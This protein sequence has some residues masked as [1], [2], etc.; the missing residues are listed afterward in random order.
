MQVKFTVKGPKRSLARMFT[1][2]VGVTK[3]LSE[4]WLVQ[5]ASGLAEEVK[6]GLLR[7]RF[8]LSEEW[9]PLDP[10]YLKTKKKKKLD[11]RTL[12]ATK[13]Y[14]A[15]IASWR[16]GGVIMVGVRDNAKYPDGTPVSHIAAIHEYGRGNSPSRPHWVPTIRKRINNPEIYKDYYDSVKK[17][18]LLDSINNWLSSLKN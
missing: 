11:T 4:E 18:G 17:N 13:R 8:K 10:N 6:E 15:S 5:Q 2:L 14:V 9:V 12:I 1:D 3:K 16:E 7:G